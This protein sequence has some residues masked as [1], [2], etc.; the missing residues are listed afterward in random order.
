MEEIKDS[1]IYETANFV[2]FI[3]QKPHVSREEGGHLCITSKKE[4]ISSRLDLSPQLAKEFIRLSMLTGEAMVL[5]LAER[6]IAVARVN[7]QENGNWAFLKDEPPF[8]HLHI[9]GRTKDSRHQKWG[10]KRYI[11]QIP[12]PHIMT[13]QFL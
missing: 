13:R 1:I 2:I 10:G 3:P 4:Q 5:G 7:Y 11:F 6:N 12:S 9:Y 8:F